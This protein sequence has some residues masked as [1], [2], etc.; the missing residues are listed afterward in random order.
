MLAVMRRRNAGQLPKVARTRIASLVE[1]ESARNC[2]RHED[3]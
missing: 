2:P 3:F 1:Q